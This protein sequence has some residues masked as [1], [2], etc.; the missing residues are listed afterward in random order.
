MHTVQVYGGGFLTLALGGDEG[1]T[2]WPVCVT[3]GKEIPVPFE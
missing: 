3:L 1:S 2:W